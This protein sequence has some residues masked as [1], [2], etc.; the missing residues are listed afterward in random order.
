MKIINVVEK[1]VWEKLDEIMSYK[2]DMCKCDKCKTDIVAYVLNRMDAK[3]VASEKGE[4]YA[5]AE[6]LD[7]DFNTALIVNLTEAIEVVAANPRHDK[8]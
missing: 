3:Y 1:I 6:Y 4:L 2:P 7:K 8:E 5:R